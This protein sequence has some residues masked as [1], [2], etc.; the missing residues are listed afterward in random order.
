M[1]PARGQRRA[2]N[3]E[4]PSGTQRVEF[5]SAQGNGGQRIYLLPQY[6]LVVVFTGGDYNS[7]AAPPNKIM[8]EVIL[9]AVT[10]ETAATVSAG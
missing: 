7:G 9:P 1:A 3:V 4:T 8:A 10:A 2:L 5:S 6:D